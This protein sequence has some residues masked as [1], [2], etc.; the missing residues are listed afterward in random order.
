[1]R[2]YE[3]KIRNK[4]VAKDK[5]K[6][7]YKSCNNCTCAS[8]IF[9]QLKYNSLEEL[10]NGQCHIDDHPTKAINLMANI[11]HTSTSSDR[12]P[13]STHFSLLCMADAF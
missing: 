4:K 8:Y 13:C 12:E 2:A 10:I 3:K 6:H 5:F 11:F 1:M 7:S 9:I